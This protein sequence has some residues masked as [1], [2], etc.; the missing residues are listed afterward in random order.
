MTSYGQFCPVA[1]ATEIVGDKWTM[2]ILRELLLGTCRFNDFQRALSKISPTILTKRLKFLDEKGVVLRRPLSGQKGYEYRLTPAGKELEPLVEQLAVWGMRWARGQM[3]DEELDVELLMWDIHRR[4]LTENLPDG[5]TVLCFTFTDLDKHKS[6]WLV[7]NGEEV[8]LCTRDPGKD[9]DLY[10][11]TALR[12]MVDIWEG[13]ADLKAA[14]RD[15]AILAIGLPD[16]IRSMP[17]W[18]GL[19]SFAEIRPVSPSAQP[20]RNF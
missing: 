14:L 11:S 3:S 2:L 12:T 17:D 20:E 1:K 13:D 18:F 4:I 15:E 8:D 19:C 5:Q 10:V 16:L 7:I 6:W 9:V